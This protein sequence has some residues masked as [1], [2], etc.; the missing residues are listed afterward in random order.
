LKHL[1]EALG[2]SLMSVSR[3]LNGHPGVSDE[4]RGRVR[5][6]AREMGYRPNLAARALVTGRTH[7]VALWMTQLAPPYYA[8]VIQAVQAHTEAAGYETLLWKTSSIGERPS[9]LEH[10]P[11]DGVLDLDGHFVRAGRDLSQLPPLVTMGVD[12]TR[13]ADY[14]GIDLLGGAA[15]AVRHLLAQGRR[16]IAYLLPADRNNDWDDQRYRAYVTTL[17]EAG[18]EPEF[19]PAASWTRAGGREA[20]DAHIAARGC[21]DGLFC[22]NDVLAIGAYRAL[23]DRGLRLPDDVALV[24]C[25]GIE[26]VEF[27]DTPLSTIVQPVEEMCALAWGF[28]QRRMADPACPPQQVVLPARLRVAASSRR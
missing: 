27:L 13:D 2:L 21:P 3:A 4:T 9:P 24:G 7:T 8:R 15:E 22:T 16:R 25:D 10:W 20:L 14:V 12:Y 28:L 11:V 18:R 6:A 5:R 26:D 17:R 19:I 23:R 1:A